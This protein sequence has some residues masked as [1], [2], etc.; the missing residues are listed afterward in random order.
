MSPSYLAGAALCIALFAAALPA[1]SQQHPVYDPGQPSTT[2]ISRADGCFNFSEDQVRRMITEKAGFYEIQCPNCTMGVQGNQLVWDPEH[3]DQ[4]KCRHCGHVYPSEKY[5]MDKV[6]EHQAPT[7]EIQKYPYYERADGF[8]HFFQA[9]IDFHARYYFATKAY[10]CALAYWRTK[11]TKYARRAVV[12][13][14]RMAEVYPHLPIHGLDGYTFRRPMWAD[15]EPP[16]PY[17]SQ[18]LGST[19]F[20]SE[21]HTGMVRAYDMLYDSGEFEKLSAELG[22]DVKRMVKEDLIEA[23]ADFTLTFPRWITNMTPS[24]CNKLIVAGRVVGKPNYVH[25]A[26]N[27]LRKVLNEQFFADGAWSEAA[28]SYHLQTAGGLGSAFRVAVGY[29][30]P[31][32]YSFPD[33]GERFDDYDPF[34]AEPF[35]KKVLVGMEPVAYPDGAYCCVHDT[36][37]G[38]KTKPSSEADSTLLWSMGHAILESQ[39]VTL[40]AEAQLHFSGAHGHAHADPLNLTYWAYGHELVS[41]LGYTHTI[42]RSYAGSGAAHNLVIVN[43]APPASGGREIPWPGDLRLWH[44]SGEVC[45][46]ISVSYPAYSNCDLYERTVALIDRPD[47]PAY[48]VDFFDVRGGSQ[49]DWLMRGSA[50]DDQTASANVPLEKLDYTLLGPDRKLVP[51]INEGGYRLVAVG[52]KRAND[53]PPDGAELQYNPYGLI[54]DLQRG[55][56][57]G[58]FVATFRYAEPNKPSMALHLLAGNDT[59]YYLATTPS[60]KRSKTDSATVDDVRQPLVIARRTGAD[61][62]ESRFCALLWPYLDNS[63]APSFT[64]LT[65]GGNIVGAEIRFD[66][67]TDLVIAPTEKPDEPITIAEHPLQT[68]AA[69]AFI[70]LRDGV[71]VAAELNAGTLLKLGEFKL[72][73]GGPISGRIIAANGDPANPSTEIKVADMSVEHTP[74]P[75]SL[76]FVTHADGAFSLMKLERAEVRDAATYLHLTEPPDFSV[77]GDKT[78]FH[79]Y[80]IREADGIPA[81]VIQPYA[82]WT[83]EP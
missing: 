24:W 41:D 78:S 50:D 76:L 40:A 42:Y 23:M 47:A 45:K 6:Y 54:R 36:W 59:D 9:N 3:P 55:R 64:P 60:I 13:L 10:D 34:A 11:D 71:P 29:S 4:V 15:N 72:T 79:Y 48:L 8:H 65:A 81:F 32:G 19:W 43:E 83:V 63:A 82:T 74:V 21:I 7:G 77:A 30:D 44:P 37:A 12:I 75:G 22:V 39:T 57:A 14:Q 61:G 73:C 28:V 26:V 56:T 27:M 66:D 49:H 17:L 25:E 2:F 80:P 67:Y 38:T 5:P 31:A 35:L 46:A 51:Y 58:N 62:L 33:T 16:H 20:Y 68:D 1:S 52:A 53:K 69:F 18:K 70:R